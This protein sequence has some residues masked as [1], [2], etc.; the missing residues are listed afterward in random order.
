MRKYWDFF[1]VVFI[2]GFVMTV[3]WFKRKFSPQKQI[4]MI[5]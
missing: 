3:A 4:E 1:Y 2:I 5:T